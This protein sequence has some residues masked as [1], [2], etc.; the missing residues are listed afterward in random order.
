[1]FFFGL[2]GTFGYGEHNPQPPAYAVKDPGAPKT[3]KMK[4]GRYRLTRKRLPRQRYH[5]ASG[6]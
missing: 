3:M 6:K 5:R 2:Y 4:Y 1:M